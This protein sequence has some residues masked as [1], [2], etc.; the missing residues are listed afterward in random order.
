ME[1][2]SPREIVAELDQY[3]VGQAAAKR[4][5]AIA[6]RN[7][8]RRLAVAPDLRE[9][10]MP[11]NIL[12][13][14]PTGVG[15]TELARR[16]ARLAGAPFLKVEASKFTEVGYVGRDVESIVRDL[17]EIAVG[18]VRTERAE[19]VEIRA[20]KHVEERLV[21]LLCPRSRSREVDPH[22]YEAER[23]AVRQD[24]RAGRLAERMIEIDL[25]SPRAGSQE[26]LSAM[27]LKDAP[28]G[29]FDPLFPA[30]K[31]RRRVSLAEGERLLI[32]EETRKMVDDDEVIPAAI[33]RAESLGIV[34]LD[35][36]DKI[37]GP[38]GSTGPEVS[39]EGVQRD[40]LPII[41]GSAVSTRFG[42]VRTDHV[43][44]IAAGAFHHAR[45]SDLLPELQGRLPIRVELESLT[46]DDFLRIL[47][48]PRNALVRQYQALLATEGVHLELTPAALAR[49]ASLAFRLNAEAENIGARRLHTVLNRL[50][51]DLL[52]RAPEL[53]DR[54]VCLDAPDVDARLGDLGGGHDLNRYIL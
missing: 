4:A 40:L 2:L 10:I 47:T 26:L 54:E 51:D 33:E 49:I 25:E 22:V 50:L 35:E 28:A 12:M 18:M 29:L 13:I 34:F 24:L 14:G 36:I 20:R 11:S 42:V 7:R 46:A 31:K 9:E 16:L 39:R 44:F 21:N 23:E 8:Y 38:R 3:V 1:T 48:E 15:K 45:P 53:A 6:L 19:R 17:I 43:L 52:F 37:I 27:G 30:R 5:L 41:E 32:Q